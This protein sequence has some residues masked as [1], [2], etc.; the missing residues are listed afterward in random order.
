MQNMSFFQNLIHTDTVKDVP[1]TADCLVTTN[2]SSPLHLRF[3]NNI[4]TVLVCQHGLFR[5]KKERGGILRFLRENGSARA[6]VGR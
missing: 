6:V 4:W 2:A 1:L 3:F 5:K